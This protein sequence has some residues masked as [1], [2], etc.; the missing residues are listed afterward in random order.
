[1]Y[2]SSFCETAA[3]QNYGHPQGIS[4]TSLVACDAS[5]YMPI[6]MDPDTSI[7]IQTRTYDKPYKHYTSIIQ[8]LY[9]QNT[10]TFFDAQNL[11]CK[12][13]CYIRLYRVYIA[14]MCLYIR[15]V[16][17]MCMYYACICLYVHV[18][19]CILPI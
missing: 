14:C 5:R 17:C 19:A 7:Q 2:S 6:Q 11:I 8:A 12:N 9:K 10:S 18:F 15:G 3:T 1:M 13:S 4:L 16:V